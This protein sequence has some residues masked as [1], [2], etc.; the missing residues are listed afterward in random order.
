MKLKIVWLVMV[1]A[2][3]IGN[4]TKIKKSIIGNNNKIENKDNFI[5]TIIITI[6]TGVVIAG[7][8]YYL[9]WN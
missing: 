1:M 7:I 5:I 4:N 6:M 3:K 2:I 8:V 9:G